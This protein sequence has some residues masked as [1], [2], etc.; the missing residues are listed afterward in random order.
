MAAKNIVTA[1][2]YK[3]YI[4]FK[5]K[6]KGLYIYGTFGLG[7]KTFINKETVDYYEVIGEEQHKSF[8]S[9]VARGIAGAALF[10]GIGA[11]AGASSAK[12]K[13]THTVSIVFK[14]GTKCL[15]ELDDSMFKK[16]VTVMY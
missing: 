10:G 14:D 11:I 4:D 15:C 5:N 13:G 16:F 7:K 2:D 8:G 12:A 9:G 1:G 6:K 3:G